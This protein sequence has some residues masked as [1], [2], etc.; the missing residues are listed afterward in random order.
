MSSKSCTCGLLEAWSVLWLYIAFVYFPRSLWPSR[1]WCG[2]SVLQRESMKGII[3]T[4]VLSSP[5]SF[6]CC[7]NSFHKWDRKSPFY[8]SEARLHPALGTFLPYQLRS[9][10]QP[11]DAERRPWG[12]MTCWCL[13]CDHRA[14]SGLT[15][16]PAQMPCF[17]VLTY[18]VPPWAD[19]GHLS[20]WALW[21]ALRYSLSQKQ[22]KAFSFLYLPKLSVSLVSSEVFPT[23]TPF[24]LIAVT[25]DS[26]LFSLQSMNFRS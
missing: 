18:W 10:W 24:L 1:A 21:V 7:Y 23:P 2:D 20:I 17:P 3:T 25:K 14:V 15:V 8:M 13:Q 12:G 11:R 26:W 4:P 6:C 19:S 5:V 16:A 9:L 22:I